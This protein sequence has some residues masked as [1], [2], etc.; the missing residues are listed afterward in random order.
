MGKGTLISAAVGL[1]TLPTVTDRL[2]P[3][4]LTTLHDISRPFMT[5]HN[6]RVAE[7]EGGSKRLNIFT[8]KI[9]TG[10]RW[11]ANHDRLSFEVIRVHSRSFVIHCI[12]RFLHQTGLTWPPFNLNLPEWE[13]T[14]MNRRLN[15]LQALILLLRIDRIESMN[16]TPPD[17]D[18]DL[19]LPSFFSCCAF[20]INK[21]SPVL[22]SEAY[23][24]CS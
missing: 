15:K 5:F 14:K 13:K 23:K 8:G 4:V 24:R 3:S 7:E 9:G 2:V 1:P 21:R 12:Q 17:L 22:E 20:I 19:G 10:F 11:I 16:V 6:G 18:R